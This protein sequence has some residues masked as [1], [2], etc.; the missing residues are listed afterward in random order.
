MVIFSCHAEVLLIFC[1]IGTQLLSKICVAAWKQTHKRLVVR[2]L[3]IL[4]IYFSLVQSF[5]QY[6]EGKTVTSF[7]SIRLLSVCKASKSISI[8][9]LRSELN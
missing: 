7:K 5:I 2:I 6:V 8:C 4:F 3:Y 1:R 9:R